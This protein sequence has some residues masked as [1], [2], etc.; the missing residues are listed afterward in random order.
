[1]STPAVWALRCGLP[2]VALAFLLASVHADPPAAA[3]ANQRV[4]LAGDGN[5]NEVTIAIDPTDPL[6]LAAAS[7]LD[8]VYESLDG[9]STW[10]QQRLGGGGLGVWG[11]PSLAFD[12]RGRLFFAH[13]S[14]PHEGYWIDRIVVQRSLDG[15][16]SFEAGVGI[17][18]DPPRHQDK[19]W[20]AADLTGSRYHDSLYVLW[21]EFDRYGSADPGDRSRVRFARSTDEGRTW[22]APLTVSDAEGDALDGDGTV[23]GAVPTVGPSG[24][25]YTAW[26]GPLGIM[27]DRSTDGGVSFGR[28]VLVSEQPGGWAFAVPGLRRAN[29]LPVTL[30][31]TSDSRYRGRIYVV[32]SDQRAGVHDTD[33]FVSHSSDAGATWSLAVRVNDDSR[34]RHQFLHWAALD[35][36]TGHL[37]VVFYDRR[38]TTGNATEVF[39]A[40]STDGAQ[41]FANGR[42]SD[43]PFT[44][45]PDRFL[46]DYIGIAAAGGHVHAIWTRMDS[47]RTS[48]WTARVE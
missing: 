17:G 41:S 37:Y 6:H 4:S 45:E 14:N 3:R 27:L 10:R 20:I 46:G 25:I 15:G 19:S 18:L 34:G 26:S 21:T 42:I 7:N 12:S 13:L 29:G 28:D 1:M 43:A 44:A 16:R 36:S 33:V 5:P 23:E 38:A 24:E 2:P 11:D 30:C 31:D 40:R 39:V 32:W 35:R 48:V 8:F 9:G 22:S 47:G